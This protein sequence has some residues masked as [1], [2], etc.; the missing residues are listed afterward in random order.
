MAVILKQNQG[1]LGK[2]EIIMLTDYDNDN[3]Y[4]IQNA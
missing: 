4:L 2:F 3:R 1:R